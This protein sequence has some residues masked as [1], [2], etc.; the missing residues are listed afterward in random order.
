M[1]A[2]ELTKD[3]TEGS[4]S[5]PCLICGGTSFVPQFSSVPA[6]ERDPNAEPYRIT[7]SERRFVG[8]IER[9]TECGM[10]ALPLDYV[11]GSY[12]DAA[13]PYYLEQEEE[14]I[15]NSHG[16][17]EYIPSGGRLLEIGCAVGFL[18]RAARERGFDAVGVEMSE[19]ASAYARD[20]LGLDVVTGRLEDVAFDA[21]SFDVVVMADV[22]EH[23]T[24][25]RATLREIRRVL[26]PGGQLLLLTP[27][28]GS[29]VARAAGARWWGLLDDHYFYFSRTNLR[30]F[31][32]SEDFV[33]DTLKSH[34]RRFPVLH[35]ISK[36]KQY[37][38]VAHRIV[39]GVIRTLGFGEFRL[40]VNLGD[41]MA[42]VARKK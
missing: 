19:W 14:R 35:W 21:D 2:S 22:I 27:D 34:G 31:L 8:A 16:L 37:N 13:D 15:A 9:C 12:S 30:R 32:E 3:T 42:C 20:E 29:I 24:D 4:A 39:A 18:L 17:L 11:P 28:A 5:D 1:H 40:N 25:P 7:H 36:L 26:K 10:V 38:E 41:M 33:V 23:L 6:P